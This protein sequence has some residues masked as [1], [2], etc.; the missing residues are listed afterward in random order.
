MVAADPFLMDRYAVSAEPPEK[1]EQGQA[2]FPLRT[3]IS[4]PSILRDS[5]TP[6]ALRGFDALGQSLRSVDFDLGGS[7]TQGIPR[8][9]ESR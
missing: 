9:D 4:T 6:S 8:W 1:G 7:R 5:A 3:P 2:L